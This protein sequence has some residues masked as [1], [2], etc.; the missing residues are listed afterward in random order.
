MTP[1]KMP[2][3]MD[4]GSVPERESINLETYRA[5]FEECNA[6]RK[7]LTDIHTVVPV[8]PQDGTNCHL[9]RMLSIWYGEGTSW[10]H[11][12]DHMGGFIEATRANIAFSFKGG[13]QE[14]FILM[15][16]NDMEPP[17]NLPYLLARHDLP[18]VG[19][20]ALSI[21]SEHGPQLCFSVK[22]VEGHWRFPAMRVGKKIPAR[23]LV[24]V[25]HVGTG[26][27]LIRRDVLDSFSFTIK[28]ANCLWEVPWS[29]ISEAG[30]NFGALAEA[31]FCK[32][33]G[34]IKHM[35]EDIPFFVPFKFR[36]LGM[37]TGNL[38]LGE[39]IAFCNQIRA[40]GFTMHVDLE[41][42]CGHRKTMAMSWDEDFREPGLDV[43]HWTVPA[44]GKRM[45]TE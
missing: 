25:G 27:I 2:P 15:I 7:L 20:P 26:A 23:G 6:N 43:E 12:N 24:E 4:E 29:V 30:D 9:T 14:K 42:H 16:D 21:D 11:L 8:R 38:T 35:Y 19:S 13:Q 17:I 31:C 28:C 18:V 44:V 10:S 41:A 36:M 39:D 22:D 45:H 33:C 40:K 34:T 37:R 5:Y 32:K 3:S 1:V